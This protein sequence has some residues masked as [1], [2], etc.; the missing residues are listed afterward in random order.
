MKHKP[1]NKSK[2]NI[3][4]PRYIS[5]YESEYEPEYEPIY[6]IIEPT[7]PEWQILNFAGLRSRLSRYGLQECNQFKCMS[8]TPTFVWLNYDEYLMHHLKRKYYRTRIYLQNSL[9]NIDSIDDKDKLH[10]DMETYQQSNWNNP[11]IHDTHLKSSDRDW[12]FPDDF[13]NS[14]IT[15]PETNPGKNQSEMIPDI[16]NQNRVILTAV[17]KLLSETVELY[18][19]VKNGFNV[20]GV[21]LMI[22]SDSRGNAKVVLLE[23]NSEGT[24]KTK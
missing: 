7:N 24:Y 14:N 11:D 20:F 4:K 8:R 13:T 12:F 3:N 9:T 15:N 19:N 10:L 22:T 17:A 2:K 21:D 1:I 18:D 23:C 5:E 6:T 16:I